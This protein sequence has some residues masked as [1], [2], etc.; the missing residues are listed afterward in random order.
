MRLQAA[1]GSLSHD[2]ASTQAQA[3]EIRAAYRRLARVSRLDA[4]YGAILAL[5]LPRLTVAVVFSQQWHPDRHRGDDLAK[6][7]FQQIQEAYEVLMDAGKRQSYDLK[8]VHLLPVEVRLEL[9]TVS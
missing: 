1:A 6:R 2:C 8:L 4:G 3:D 5:L 7:R 9:P